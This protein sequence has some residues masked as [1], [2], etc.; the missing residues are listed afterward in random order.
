MPKV[1][2]NLGYSMKPAVTKKPRKSKKMLFGGLKK[3]K[4]GAKK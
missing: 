4:M 2:K 1:T 3:K